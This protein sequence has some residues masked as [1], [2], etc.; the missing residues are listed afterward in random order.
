MDAEGQLLVEPV[1]P[2]TAVART[3]LWAQ[4]GRADGCSEGEREEEEEDAERLTGN[5]IFSSFPYLL[6][7]I[8][9]TM[10]QQEVLLQQFWVEPLQMLG[11]SSFSHGINATPSIRGELARALWW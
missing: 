3:S 4:P 1:P 5:S 2:Y 6:V 11:Y 8:C 9:P 7:P 10:A